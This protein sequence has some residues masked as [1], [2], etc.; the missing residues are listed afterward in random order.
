MRPVSEPGQLELE[1]ARADALSYDLL[2][3]YVRAPLQQQRLVAAWGHGKGIPTT[4]H[5]HY[6]AANFGVDN[7]EHLGATSRFGYSRTVSPNGGAYEDVIKLF[8]S[9]EMRRTPTLF[10]ASTLLD[11]DPGLQDDPRIK[12]LY[13]SWERA[14]LVARTKQ[15][16]TTDQAGTRITLRKGVEQVAA[17][18]KSGGKV[19][20]GT[21]SPIDLNCIGH[22]QVRHQPLRGPAHRHPL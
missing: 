22:D 20:S 7:M 18:L 12:A 17:M 13:P 3:S 9:S 4:G 2:K 21:D 19:I 6:P 14:K 10:Q 8:A 5:Y 11:E 15:A 16:Q 1:L